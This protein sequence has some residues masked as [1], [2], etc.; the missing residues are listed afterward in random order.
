MSGDQHGAHTGRA[1]T[2][3]VGMKRVADHRDPV[4]VDIGQL[5]EGIV[6]GIAEGLSKEYRLDPQ[7]VCQ[8]IGAISGLLAEAGFT[9]RDEVGVGQGD[10]PRTNPQRSLE[11]LLEGVRHSTIQSLNHVIHKSIKPGGS[12][13]TEEAA[14]TPIYLVI[15]NLGKGGK[16]VLEW[17]ATRNQFA[18]MC[19]GCFNA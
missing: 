11:I 6:E 15:R 4:P 8:S 10:A 17:F 7:P 2:E 5:G 1:S 12:F 19:G 18:T 3:N 9:R 14:T 13:S 16:N